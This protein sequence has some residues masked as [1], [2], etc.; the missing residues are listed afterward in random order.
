[1]KLTKL[2]LIILIIILINLHC[3]YQ[4]FELENT[5]WVHRYHPDLP[6][7]SLFLFDTLFIFYFAERDMRYYGEYYVNNDTI[8]FER[9]GEIWMYDPPKYVITD[10]TKNIRGRAVINDN[11]KLEYLSPLRFEDGI[12]IDSGIKLGENTILENI[13]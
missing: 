12:W 9:Q 4:S 3:S 5:K 13:K 7:D 8:Y 10:D 11:G 2:L 1:M 6:A